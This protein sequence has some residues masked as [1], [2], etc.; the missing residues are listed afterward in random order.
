MQPGDTLTV[1]V[2]LR[3]VAAVLPPVGV[4]GIP[5]AAK[6]AGFQDRRR[7][8]FGRFLSEADIEKA[9]GTRLSEKLRHLPGIL[10]I[11]PRTG[12]SSNVRIATT[13]GG[14]GFNDGPCLV[15]LIVDGADPGGFQCQLHPSRRGSGD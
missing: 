4:T 15:R 10:V 9:P 1:D 2:R 6:L 3:Q 14:R 7:L 5:V 8:G 12:F 13:R 11:Y